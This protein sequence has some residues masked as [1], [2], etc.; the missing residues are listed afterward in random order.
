MCLS[1][2]LM[3]NIQIN[4]F[5]Y[6]FSILFCIFLQYFQEKIDQ[7]QNKRIKGPVIYCTVYPRSFRSDSPRRTWTSLSLYVGTRAPVFTCVCVCAC[8]RFAMCHCV[9]HPATLPGIIDP[10]VYC[11]HASPDTIAHS[12]RCARVRSL[13]PFSLSRDNARA[14]VSPC[15][16]VFG[17]R[18]DLMALCANTT[19][20]LFTSDWRQIVFLVYTANRDLENN[21]EDNVPC[22]NK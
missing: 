4:S 17:D 9:A 2:S 16:C 10:L 12:R 22:V 5:Q 21:R 8:I 11:G 19:C 1:I 7:L 3:N 20:S 15:V 14:R 13:T 6:T 18:T